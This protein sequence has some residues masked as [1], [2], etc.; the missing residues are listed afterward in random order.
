MLSSS[1]HLMHIAIQ[2]V[3]V[4]L[5]GNTQEMTD[6]FDREEVLDAAVRLGMPKLLACCERRSASKGFPNWHRFP[7]SSRLR[8]YKTRMRA[9]DSDPWEDEWECQIDN[10]CGNAFGLTCQP[11]GLTLTARIPSAQDFLSMA[12]PHRNTA[13]ECC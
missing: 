6:F 5:Y 12:R 2:F 10:H 3:A 4:I 1:T 7:V 8:L 13:V 11:A 9:A